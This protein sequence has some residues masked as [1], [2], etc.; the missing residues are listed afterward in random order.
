MYTLP[1]GTKIKSPTT[2]YTITG[3]LGQG[4]FGITYSATFMLTVGTMKVKANVALKEHFVKADCVRESDT[5]KVSCSDPARKRVEFTRKDFMGEARRLN[6]IS[7]KNPNIVTV[8]EVFEANNTAYY[9]MEMI[10]GKSLREYVAA[11]GKLSVGETL[12]IITPIIE[13]AAF[14]HSNRITHLDIKPQNIMIATDESGALRPVLIDFGLSKHYDENGEA[15]STLK[16]MGYSEGFSPVEQYAGITHFSPASDVYALAATMVFCLTGS[17]LPKAHEV[18][19]QKLDAILPATLPGALRSILTRSLSMHADDRYADAAALLSAIEDDTILNI[20]NGDT[21]VDDV[22]VS[23]VSPPK[24]KPVGVNPKPVGHKKMTPTWL[25]IA[26]IV[27][28]A[29]LIGCGIVYFLTNSSSPVV[30]QPIAAEAPVANDSTAA[31]DA[32]LATYLNAAAE[33]LNNV[34]SADEFNAVLSEIEQ[35]I[36]AYREAQPNS[37]LTPEIKEAL[38]KAQ[39]AFHKKAKELNID[40][41]LTPLD[42]TD[43]PQEPDD[44]AEQS[45]YS[46]DNL[47]PIIQSGKMGFA[48]KNGNIVIPCVYEITTSFSEGLARVIKDGKRGYIDKSSNKVISIEYNGAWPFREGLAR[49]CQDDKYGFIN[50]SG[51][52]VI[53]LIYDKASDF[54]EGLA[55]VKK[56][57]KYGFI[58]KSGKEV[59]PRFYDNACSFYEGLARVNKDGKWGF[60]NK[61]GDVVI[62]LI[63]EF[64]DDFHEG[65]AEVEKDGKRGYINKSGNVAI[66]PIYDAVQAFSEG[67][68]VVRI[69]SYDNGKYGFIDKFG[70]EVI[71]LIYDDAE[72]FSEGLADVEKFGKHGFINKAGKEVIP[73]I[74]DEAKHFCEGFASVKKNG[75]WGY[76]DNMGN[77]VAPFDYDN[78]QTFANGIGYAEKNGLLYI[79]DK[80]GNC[81]KAPNQ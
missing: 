22:A 39:D 69:G 72:N 80:F 16:T 74:Y 64:V 42:V 4:G 66:P 26:L 33:Q 78:A 34:S 73:S 18:T 3:V 51:D 48:D 9:A 25:L 41:D 60:I 17:R 1:V 75:K 67:L 43:S 54:S 11:R 21:T 55:C 8:N 46:D 2:T 36:H 14:L 15:T 27:I 57:G 49:V 58:N 59:I 10:E 61:S 29:G 50:K 62:P 13:A 79:I 71:P 35:K 6:R 70:K 45:Q 19:P 30:E 76:I 63:Y 52:V 68:A 47:I 40:A 56:N 44:S 20:P 81:M 65:L 28:A 5:S 38:R 7:G 31:A 12:S 32:E 37:T 53:P 24:K 77:K 23:V